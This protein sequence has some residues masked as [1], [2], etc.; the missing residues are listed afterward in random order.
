MREG[1]RNTKRDSYNQENL[2]EHKR[3]K[4]GFLEAGK[5]TG[6]VRKKICFLQALFPQKCRLNEYSGLRDTGVRGFGNRHS[7]SQK[8]M[9]PGMETIHTMP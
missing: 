5:G 6:K 8:T 3:K 4:T 7:G 2:R 1:K 9:I